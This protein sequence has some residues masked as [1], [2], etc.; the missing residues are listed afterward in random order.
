MFFP[1]SQLSLRFLQNNN[2]Q[3][4]KILKHKSFKKYFKLIIF[5]SK[6]KRN[7]KQIENRVKSPM[8]YVKST[9]EQ[10]M[11][12]GKIKHVIVQTLIY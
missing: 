2:N 11:F 6:I 7:V 1:L 5:L 12:P 4:K 10:L 9:S 8:S 3:K